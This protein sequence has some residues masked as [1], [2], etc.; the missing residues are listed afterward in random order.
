MMQEKEGL[1]AS[2]NNLRAEGPSSQQEGSLERR[3][4][5]FIHRSEKEVRAS[6][7]MQAM[8]YFYCFCYSVK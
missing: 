7:Q 4:E 6:T 8:S 2:V 3:A 1:T 5:T